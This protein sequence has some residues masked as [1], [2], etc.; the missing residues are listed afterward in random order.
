MAFLA[1]KTPKNNIKKFSATYLLLKWIIKWNIAE[2]FN[3]MFLITNIIL[4]MGGTNSLDLVDLRF[5]FK[6]NMN[7]YGWVWLRSRSYLNLDMVRFD[8]IW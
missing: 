5:L 2:V 1:S 3:L 6:L 8:S 7:K 4:V